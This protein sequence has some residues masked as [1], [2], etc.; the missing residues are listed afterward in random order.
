M[1]PDLSDE[2]HVSV[3]EPRHMVL[4]LCLIL[5]FQMAKFRL[6]LSAVEETA[7]EART[8]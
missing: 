1:K 2:A 5:T 8:V 3:V 4:A 7:M 6:P